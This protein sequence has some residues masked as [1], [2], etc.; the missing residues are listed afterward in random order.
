M[1]Q[2]I[3][4]TVELKNLSFTQRLS[5]YFINRSGINSLRQVMS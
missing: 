5:G 1:M 2:D 4:F 3:D